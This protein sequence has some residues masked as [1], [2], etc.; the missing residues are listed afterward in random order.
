MKIAERMHELIPV[1]IAAALWEQVINQAK[2]RVI[3]S[4]N[5]LKREI[6]ELNDTAKATATV[7]DRVGEILRELSSIDPA[8]YVNEAK[9]SIVPTGGKANR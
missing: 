3:A 2:A 1:A 9:A 8:D 5:R 7:D 4:G 6:V